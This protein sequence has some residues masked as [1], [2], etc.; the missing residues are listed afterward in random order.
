MLPNALL[1]SRKTIA[2]SFL[3]LIASS[4]VSVEAIREVSAECHFLFP[5]RLF[6]RQSFVCCQFTLNLKLMLKLTG[7]VSLF[8]RNHQILPSN[9]LFFLS[10]LSK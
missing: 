8:A 3:L 2:V 9:L 5:L 4:I 1:I 10:N 7:N 6:H